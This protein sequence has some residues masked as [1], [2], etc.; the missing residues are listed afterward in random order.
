MAFSL[1][2]QL[3]KDAFFMADL[4]LCQLMLMN[5]QLFPW[6]ILVPRKEDIS[7]IMDLLPNCR[8]QLMDEIT[9][10]SQLIKKLF[11]ADKLNVAAL[12]NYVPQLHIHVIAR[13]ISDKAWPNPVWGTFQEPYSDPQPIIAQIRQEISTSSLLA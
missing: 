3:G 2:P 7:E 4:K 6:L 11:K 12:G 9:Y 1:H 5:N 13:F 8:H 10:I